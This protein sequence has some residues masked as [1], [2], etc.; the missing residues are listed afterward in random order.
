MAYGRAGRRG[1]AQQVLKELVE[2]SNRTYVNPFSFFSVHIALGQNDQALKRLEEAVQ[3][4]L[5]GMI[6]IQVNPELDPIRSDPRFK[7]LVRS[8]GLSD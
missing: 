3:S 6:F 8:M 2:L 7:E 4:H 5:S 1:E